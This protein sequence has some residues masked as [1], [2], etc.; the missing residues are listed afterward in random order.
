MKYLLVSPFTNVSGSAIRFWNIANHLVMQ[1]H[2][3]VY[4]ERKPKNAP[5]AHLS[6]VKYY[7]TPVLNFLYVDILFSFVH[8]LSILFRN[9][10]CDV[11]YALK[12]SPNNGVPALIAKLLRKKIILDVDDLDWG[13]FKKGIKR[14]ISKMVFTRLPKHFDLITYHTKKLGTYLFDTCAVPEKK[15]HF[16]AQGISDA[17]VN[18]DLAHA[19]MHKKHTIV[20]CATLGI[21]SDLGDILPV[22]RTLLIQFPQLHISIIGDGVRRAAFEKQAQEFPSKDRIVFL[23]RVEHSALPAIIA[24]HTIGVNYMRTGLTN[25][26][27][28]VFKIRE[29][30]SLGLAVV[31][32]D[33]GDVQQFAEH[34]YIEQTIGAMESRLTTLLNN[35]LTHNKAGR[36]FILKNYRW[37]D[38]V[39]GLCEKMGKL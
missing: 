1:G 24:Q 27:R 4:V 5:T 13:Y 3:V 10:D 6:G 29:Y 34:I 16:L 36:D 21:T 26:C 14:T 20:Y 32:N 23:G 22:F 8:N 12:P 11:Y 28:A 35:P 31:C 19:P 38:G 30:L 33:V 15:L 2:T 17:F 18:Y 37:E 9:L 25:N 39:A 7:S